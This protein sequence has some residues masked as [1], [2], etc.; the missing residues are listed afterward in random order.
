MEPLEVDKC[1]DEVEDGGG[2]DEYGQLPAQPGQQ[3]KC[4]VLL[5]ERSGVVTDRRVKLDSLVKC[6]SL[7]FVA[8]IGI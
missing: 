6:F 8:G 2:D 1:K 3:V 5:G 7:A 4:V